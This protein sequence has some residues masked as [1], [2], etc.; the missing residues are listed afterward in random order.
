MWFALSMQVQN[1]ISKSNIH[2]YRSL[3]KGRGWGN[4]VLIDKQLSLDRISRL[5]RN[6]QHII[7]QID[8]LIKK[9]K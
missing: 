2:Q 8:K 1:M 5:T 3:A 7:D 4:K 9:I 6:G